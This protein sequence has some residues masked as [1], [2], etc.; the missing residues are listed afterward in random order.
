MRNIGL[1]EGKYPLRTD[2]YLPIWQQTQNFGSK[3]KTDVP[4]VLE[5]PVLDTFHAV[6]ADASDYTS[7]RD[8][9]KKN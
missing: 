3:H 6:F 9:V 7:L 2:L 1:W 4:R 5:T 8:I